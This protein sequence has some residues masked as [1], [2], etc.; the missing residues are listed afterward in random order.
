MS[1]ET[2][3]E[4]RVKELEKKMGYLWEALRIVISSTAKA[5]DANEQNQE[6]AE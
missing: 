5:L 2:H 3:L 1:A 6:E 4:E